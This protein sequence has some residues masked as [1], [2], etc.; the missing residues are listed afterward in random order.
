[1]NTFV[2]R[3]QEQNGRNS[4]LH[5]NDELQ[6]IWICFKIKNIIKYLFDL[7]FIINHL[8]QIACIPMFALRDKVKK[9]W[10]GFSLGQALRLSSCVQV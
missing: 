2:Q 7:L 9:P 10:S 6:K 1:M 3:C 5:G 8:S 4:F